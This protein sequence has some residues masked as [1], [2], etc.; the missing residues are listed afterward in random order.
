MYVGTLPPPFD[1]IV[2]PVASWTVRAPVSPKHSLSPRPAVSLDQTWGASWFVGARTRL[3]S[4]FHSRTVESLPMMLW[5]SAGL[6]LHQPTVRLVMVYASAVEASS[7]SAP[8]PS[9]A[10]TRYLVTDMGFSLP[11]TRRPP[12]GSA[13]KVSGHAGYS[14]TITCAAQASPRAAA[15]A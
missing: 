13:K 6:P 14:N 4:V 8:R 10:R 7:A 15:G 2:A 3:P 9:A 1:Q 12:A 5:S 11:M